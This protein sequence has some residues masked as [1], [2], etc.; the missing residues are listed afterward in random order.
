MKAAVSLIITLVLHFKIN[1]IDLPTVRRTFHSAVLETSKVPSFYTYIH[2]LNSTEAIIVAYQA[3]SE[4]LLAQQEWNPLEKYA[5]IKKF[6]EL[7]NRA[8]FADPNNLEI[9]FLRFCIEFYIPQ[10]LGISNHIDDDKTF[11]LNHLSDA[12]L[13]MFDRGFIRY[14]DYFMKE[15][16]LYTTEQIGTIE[17]VLKECMALSK[18]E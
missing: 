5:R 10:W 11:I 8:I 4:A 13:L 16:G 9:R 14:I 1:A 15:T 12:K 2:S 18:T 7:I 6:E 17:L 3:M